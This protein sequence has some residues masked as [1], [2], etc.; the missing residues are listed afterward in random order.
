MRRSLRA[1]VGISA[2][3]GAS[4]GLVACGTAASEDVANKQWQVTAVFDSPEL[5]PNAP[6]G[7]ISPM[8]V[9]G[10]KDYSVNS[11]CGTVQGS[12]EWND[13]FVTVGVPEVLRTMPCD[14][15]AQTFYNRYLKVLSGDFAFT[16]GENG[17]RLT[18]SR[19]AD[20]SEATESAANSTEASAPVT[21][22]RR[23]WTAVLAQ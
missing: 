23:G 16:Q 4:C 3:I 11:P 5:P 22:N 13:N 12:L 21:E 15:S 14:A 8:I 19:K 2:C 7:Q 1:L 20:D 10:A 6:D 18:Q 9:F 17:L